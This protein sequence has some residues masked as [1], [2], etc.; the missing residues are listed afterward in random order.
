MSKHDESSYPEDDQKKEK[1]PPIKRF[2]SL[3][4]VDLNEPADDIDNDIMLSEEANDYLTCDYEDFTSIKKTVDQLGY[5]FTEGGELREKGSNE[6]YRLIQREKDIDYNQK[7]YNEIGLAIT[8]HVYSLLEKA[9]MEKVIIPE[10][11][12]PDDK[13]KS[14]IYMSKDALNKE[15]VLVL[16]QGDTT[17]RAGQWSRRLIITEGLRQGTQLEYIDFGKK[18]NFGVIVLN[19]N[20][21]YI[22]EYNIEDTKCVTGSESELDHVLHIWDNFLKESAIKHIGFI[23]HANGGL[24]TAFLLEERPECLERIFALAFL[25]SIHSCTECKQ[26]AQKI[27][28]QIGMEIMSV[29]TAN[30]QELTDSPSEPDV[31]VRLAVPIVRHMSTNL[32]KLLRSDYAV[33]IRLVDYDA[34]LGMTVSKVL[35]DS[36]RLSHLWD[37]IR[38]RHQKYAW[39]TSSP[40][41]STTVFRPGY[42]EI[43]RHHLPVVTWNL[44]NRSSTR[45]MILALF[46]TCTGWL[47][48]CHIFSMKLSTQPGFGRGWNIRNGGIQFQKLGRGHEPVCKGHCEEELLNPSSTRDTGAIEAIYYPD[49]GFYSRILLVLNTATNGYQ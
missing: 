31:T 8:T 37:S 20:L 38:M 9:E 15:A 17:I 30:T 48:E 26:E 44:M 35:D 21:N 33:E 7:K 46:L 4:Q 23:A 47:W 25:D 29:D 22:P 2:H 14:Y 10:G 28:D 43:S 5:Y 12:N 18:N 40:S 39:Y 16:V 32:D 11:A 41:R 3:P 19:P 6:P 24:V 34:V 27:L 13:L 49:P 1:K 42:V 45:V 36:V